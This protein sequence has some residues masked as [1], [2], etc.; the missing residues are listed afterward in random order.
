MFLLQYKG[1]P[2]TQCRIQDRPVPQNPCNPSPCG[3]NSQCREGPN[4]QPICS[5]L[6]SMIG[7]PPSC[8]PECVLSSEC[9][10]SKACRNNKCVDPCDPGV[11]GLNA[12]CEVRSHSPICTCPSG[13]QGDP[14]VRCTVIQDDKPLAPLAPCTPN[15][16]GPNSICKE[17]SELPVCSCQEGYIG[18][19]ITANFEFLKNIFLFFKKSFI[20]N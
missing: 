13:Y 3:P 16:C 12:R 8:R 4:G 11:C 2:F 18:G 1:D 7:S 5:C 14:F 15:P 19:K 9:D 10:L 6:S 20:F 17:V